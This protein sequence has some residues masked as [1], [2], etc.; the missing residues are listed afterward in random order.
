M[1]N[2]WIE[3]VKKFAKENGLSYGCAMSNPRLKDGYVPSVKM[4]SREK[5]QIKVDAMNKTIV[6]SLL[7]R[8]KNMTSDDRPLVLMKFNAASQ[9]IKDTIK[10][11][12][13]KYFNKLFNK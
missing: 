13:P 5:K 11:Q 7:K 10:E 4:T 9:P 12:Y 6:S 3:H 8:I 1:S 2:K